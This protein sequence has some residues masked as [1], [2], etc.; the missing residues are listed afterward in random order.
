VNTDSAI[1]SVVETCIAVVS[2]CLPTLRPLCL[3]CAGRRS[4]K[5]KANPSYPLNKCGE[6]KSRAGGLG[7]QKRN[8][9]LGSGETDEQTLVGGNPGL[10]SVET[11][12]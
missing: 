10:D 6:K 4:L 11:K 1:W 9:G 7:M 2:A 12:C 5:G 3:E 8:I